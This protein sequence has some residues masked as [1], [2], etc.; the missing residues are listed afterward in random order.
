LRL[1]GKRK[2]ASRNAQSSVKACMLSRQYT[3]LESVFSHQSEGAERAESS[4]GLNS[5]IRAEVYA[6]N[7]TPSSMAEVFVTA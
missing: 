6:E 3:P 5:H 2:L 7:P 1:G 4:S